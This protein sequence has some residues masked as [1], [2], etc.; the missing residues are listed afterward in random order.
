VAPGDKDWPPMD[1]DFVAQVPGSVGSKTGEFWVF[2]GVSWVS[3]GSFFWGVAL[4][5]V[6]CWVR[7]AKIKILRFSGT[8]VKGNGAPIN[9]DEHGFLKGTEFARGRRFLFRELLLS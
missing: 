6:S 2:L 4:E 9:T 3:L 7:F 5:S 8:E 1:T